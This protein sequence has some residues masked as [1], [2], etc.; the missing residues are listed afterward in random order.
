MKNRVRNPLSAL[1][2]GLARTTRRWA[3][4]WL[5]ALLLLFAVATAAPWPSSATT[6]SPGPFDFA[7][8]GDTGYEPGQEPMVDALFAAVHASPLQFVVHV[9]DFGG[10]SAGSCTDAHWQHR[11]IQFQASSHPLVYTPGDNDWTDCWDERAGSY[12]VLERLAALRDIFFVGDQSLGQRTLPLTRQSAQPAYAAYRENIRWT[13][14]GV[15]F[16][17][18][19]YVS[20]VL[21]RTPETD[22]EFTER[23]S[24]NLAWLAE[25]FAAARAAN[26]LGVVVFTQANPFPDY[27]AGSGAPPQPRR[28]FEAFWS[29]LETEVATFGKPVLLVHGDT[30]YFRVDYPLHRSEPACLVG[31]HA[32]RPTSCRSHYLTR[33]EVFG[34]PYHHWVQVTVDP[35][36]PM[37]FTIRS[38]L[39][40]ANL[41][42]RP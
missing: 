19:H 31:T 25:G 29:Q 8:I 34:A 26:S 14:A 12:D 3:R 37:L 35:N 2:L 18:V 39:V 16:L 1:P 27:A 6:Q 4:G 33:V 42:E 30:H 15:T 20:E 13:S 17:T 40:E 21:G 36:D 5:L 10:P 7:V 38:R 24:A 23:N 32:V 11:L 22:A 28:E 9:G 41:P